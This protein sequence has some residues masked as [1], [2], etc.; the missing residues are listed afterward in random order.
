MNFDFS[1]FKNKKD[2]LYEKARSEADILL[3][4][5]D[6]V[7]E[8]N[9]AEIEPKEIKDD[10]PIFVSPGW[11]VVPDSQRESLE[12]I[13][14]QGRK[15][16]SVSFP[17][18]KK[19]KES[20]PIPSSELQKALS[21][22]EA[23]NK[24]GVSKTDAIG[25]S[26]GGLNLAIAALLYPEKFR[27][28]VLISPAGMIENDSSLDLIKRFMIDE[29]LQEFKDG[30]YADIGS[31]FKYIGELLRYGFENRELSWEEIS[32]LAKMDIMEITKRIKK[33]GVGVGFICG[34]NDKV[35]PIA[36]IA[37]SFGKENTDHF[38]STKGNHGAFIF[39]KEH[40]LLAEK[41]L[42]DMKK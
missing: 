12:I 9:I 10:V 16:L 40:V 36:K 7:G 31:Y 24:K 17:R 42:N 6:F 41:L 32:A 37:K 25:H 21:I 15:V 34:T 35:F 4:K 38:V 1:W 14:G 11:G 33:K 2:D 8:E 30:K 39:N 5:N 13:A 19:I 18:E 28:I 26:E 20:G 23:L 22:V 27:N 3:E 29:G